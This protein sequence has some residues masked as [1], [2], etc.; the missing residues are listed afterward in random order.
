MRL[1]TPGHRV[2]RKTHVWDKKWL[3]SSSQ[4]HGVF[5]KEL[6]LGEENVGFWTGLGGASGLFH[7]TVTRLSFLL[8]AI[9]RTAED[10]TCN[11]IKCSEGVKNVSGERHCS[12]TT[13]LPYTFSLV[14][15]C[16]QTGSCT[17]AQTGLKLS[18]HH[19][20]TLRSWPFSCPSLPSAGLTVREYMQLP[21]TLT[22]VQMED[23]SLMLPASTAS[24][25]AHIDLCILVGAINTCRENKN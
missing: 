24:A 22:G 21:H 15:F 13:H 18:L 2:L 10:T 6:H 20:L 4:P 25:S 14:W 12:D 8:R 9:E 5:R 17:E 19:M 23:V 11:A 7:V 16:F 1:N 3:C